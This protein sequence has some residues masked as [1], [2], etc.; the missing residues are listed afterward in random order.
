MSWSRV[1]FIDKNWTQTWHRKWRIEEII[2]HI[3]RFF[4]NN[5]QRSRDNPEYSVRMWQNHN[6]YL[7]IYINNQRY[8]AKHEQIIWTIKHLSL[9]STVLENRSN[10]KL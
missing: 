10:N 5:M 9:L 3:T 8:D 1:I 4:T 6:I 2:D 7:F